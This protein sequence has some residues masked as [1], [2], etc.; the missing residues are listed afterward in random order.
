MILPA[1]FRGD[2]GGV[3]GNA[4]A[5]DGDQAPAIP[6]QRVVPAN[7]AGLR[8]EA[9]DFAACGGEEVATIKDDIDEISAFQFR[10]PEL[11]AGSG[12]ECH[13]GPLHP[14]V[15]DLRLHGRI[16][17]PRNFFAVIV[18]LCPPKPNELFTIALTFVWRAVFGT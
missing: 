16:V 3:L 15:D 4:F 2:G 17:Y 1:F 5:G 7:A 12:I 18:A 8:I 11:L 9:I 13:H 14:Q 10:E 6:S